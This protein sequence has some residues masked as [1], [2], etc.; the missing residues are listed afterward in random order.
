MAP[1]V[2]NLTRAE[3]AVLDQRCGGLEPRDMDGSQIR[4]F[5]AAQ[6]KL[7]AAMV[8]VD[9]VRIQRKYRAHKERLPVSR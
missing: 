4:V 6:S 3:A 2:I 1:I 7:R 8:D 5:R 9:C